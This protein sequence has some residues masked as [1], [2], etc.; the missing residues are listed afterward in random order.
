VGG[1]DR[2]RADAIERRRRLDT[3]ERDRLSAA[4][5]DRIA[6]G[7]WYER[8]ESVGLYLATGGEVDPVRLGERTRG[9]GSSTWYPVPGDGP[10]A[11]RRWDGTA[12]LEAGPLG[13]SVPPPNDECA[14][15]E[16]DLVIVPLVLFGQH[17]VRVGRGAGHY[18]RTFAD[19]PASPGGP[20]LCGLAYDFQEDDGLTPQPWDV[21]LHIV[22]TP[23]RTLTW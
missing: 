20:L 5:V 9:R 19:R 6:D 13:I 17:G 10:M 23:T 18:D 14:G 3:A 12:P 16:L 11:F 22:V 8:S 21:P 2:L 15:D 7:D 4:I 1:L